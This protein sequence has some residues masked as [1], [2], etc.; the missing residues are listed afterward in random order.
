MEKTNFKINLNTEEI[1]TSMYMYSQKILTVDFGTFPL[2]VTF[3][4]AFSFAKRILCLG[5]IIYVKIK[6]QALLKCFFL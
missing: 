2:S 1:K 3:L 6:I 4:L 5:A